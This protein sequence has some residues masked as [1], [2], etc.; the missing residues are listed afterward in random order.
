MLGEEESI[1]LTLPRIADQMEASCGTSQPPPQ[2]IRAQDGLA[3]SRRNV[4]LP[5]SHPHRDPPT[6]LLPPATQTPAPLRRNSHPQIHHEQGAD[7][8]TPRCSSSSNHHRVPANAK[9]ILPHAAR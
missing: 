5:R 2:P 1:A 6:H 8:R 7:P 9:V 4:R 3:S